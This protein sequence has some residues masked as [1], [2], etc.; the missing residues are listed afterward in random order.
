M[1]TVNQQATLSARCVVAWYL[2]KYVMLSMLT[3]DGYRQGQRAGLVL[4]VWLAG[5]W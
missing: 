2:S 3:R 5:K 1:V 4:P